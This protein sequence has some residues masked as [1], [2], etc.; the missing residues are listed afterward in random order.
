VRFLHVLE[1]ADAGAPPP[2]AGLVRSRAGTP[3]EGA[4]VGAFA[5]LF[6]VDPAVPFTRVTYVV[7]AATT[8]QLVGGLRPG[9][10]YDVELKR[11][12]GSIEV[13]IA[14]GGLQKADEAGAIVLGS[15]AGKK[16]EP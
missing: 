9:E 6:P 7:P 2:A 13:T 5:A 8:A 15:L 12:G 16:A 11:A 14:A 1:A 3:F 10:G 4:V